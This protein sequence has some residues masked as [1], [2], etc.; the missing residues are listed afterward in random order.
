M[1]LK[2]NLTNETYIYGKFK[3]YQ[4]K[5]GNRQHRSRQM[6]T[7]QTATAESECKDGAMFTIHSWITSIDSMKW[8]YLGNLVCA[9]FLFA[10]AT[11]LLFYLIE[12]NQFFVKLLWI[13]CYFKSTISAGFPI[14]HYNIIQFFLH[15][16]CLKFLYTYIRKIISQK[17]II[18]SSRVYCGVSIYTIHNI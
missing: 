8:N 18:K 9:L 10:V 11:A 6:I 14:A 3:C 12:S 7:A 15:C 1:Q 4:N 17:N 2:L 16:Y 13:V 5:G